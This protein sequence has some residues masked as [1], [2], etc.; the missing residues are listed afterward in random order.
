MRFTDDTVDEYVPTPQKPHDVPPM[1]T[2]ISFSQKPQDVKVGWAFSF[3]GTASAGINRLC[4]DANK[5]IQNLEV[6][7]I[8]LYQHSLF[9]EA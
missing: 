1:N 3:T 9:H 6:N 7:E 8:S 2:F 5:I 4:Y